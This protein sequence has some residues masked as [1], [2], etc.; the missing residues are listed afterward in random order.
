MLL[1]MD[2]SD[3]VFL[4]YSARKLRQLCGRIEDCLGRL[5]EEQIWLRGTENDNAVGNLVLHLSGNVRQWIVAGVGGQLDI[6]Q[7][8]AEFAARS[9]LAAAGLAAQLRGV[10]E[11]AAG[12]VETL[13]PERLCEP[14]V[15]QG[16]NVTV[17]EAIYSVVEHFSG[18]TGQIIY[19]TKLLTGEDLGYHRYLQTTA[20]H[21]EQ[22]P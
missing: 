16:Y 7:R 12:I 19:T 22:M 18:H 9:G 3:R 20:A 8:D 11:E 6:R 13:A 1:D 15:V 21:T 5:S 4:D 2:S 14:L 17:L 10:V